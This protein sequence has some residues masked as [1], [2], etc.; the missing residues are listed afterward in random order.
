MRNRTLPV[1]ILRRH[2]V[3]LSR[4]DTEMSAA[5]NATI[6]LFI[7]AC[8]VVVA[9]PTTAQNYPTK[10][11][12]VIVPF[13]AGGQADIVARMV[14]QKLTDPF[15]QP[16]VLDNRP[17][18]GGAVG[19]ET[20]VRAT[21]D[22][23][24]MLFAASA[25][26]ANAAFYKLPYDPVNDVAP[27]GL[28]AEAGLIM[29]VHPSVPVKSIKELMAYDKAN[30]GKLN[31][32][33]GGTG[34]ATHLAAELFNQMAGTRTAHVPYKGTAPALTE[35][36]GGQIQLIFSGMPVVIPLLRSNRLRAIAVTTARRSNALPDIPTVAETVSG[37]EAVA[38]YGILGPKALPQ[39]IVGR[40]NSEINRI[41]QLP[42]AKERMAGHGIEP[43]GGSPEHFRE[44]LKRDVV[45]WRKVVKIASIKP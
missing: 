10:P 43:V 15:K 1:P 29:A 34:S 8:G 37:Y 21:P 25:Y 36:I 4:N 32:G 7:V 13:A 16:L 31:Y 38:W 17:G 27:I 26:A 19:T 3:R 20:A 41:L 40:W 42:E 30:P 5:I 45:K 22:G 28:I 2:S 12:R 14:T 35:L 39:D 18:G 33:S 9:D 24:T 6:S 11:I 23:Y 44:V